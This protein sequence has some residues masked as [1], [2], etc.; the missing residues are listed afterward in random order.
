MV[1]AIVVRLGFRL[2]RTPDSALVADFDDKPPSLPPARPPR[3]GLLDIFFGILQSA[4][5]AL[6]GAG[7]GTVGHAVLWTVT[8]GR[9]SPYNG[10][11]DRAMIAG[12]LFWA[13][14]GVGILVV[15]V[16]FEGETS[17]D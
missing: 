16:S 4:A 7:C 9:W 2:G 14:A 6:V 11:D 1:Q 15:L 13:I 17:L 10:R 8:L 12:L 5:E 3:P